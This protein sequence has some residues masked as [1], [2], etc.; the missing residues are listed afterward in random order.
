VKRQTEHERRSLRA[1][2][3]VTGRCAAPKA[4]SLRSPRSLRSR[5]VANVRG[6]I[7]AG[8]FSAVLAACSG[9]PTARVPEARPTDLM[10]AATVLPPM[11]EGEVVETA[12]WPRS[13]RASR[14]VIEADGWLR[15]AQGAETKGGAFPAR[16]RWLSG[17]EMDELWRQL[18][19]S[20]L[21]ARDAPGRVEGPEEAAGSSSKPVALIYAS[22]DGRRQT[23]RVVMDRA[24]PE[25]VEAERVVDRLAAFAWER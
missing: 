21:L 16:T 23:V 22:W 18:A 19:G 7:L 14:F 9:T 4:G 12:A 15:A 3:E 11:R 24:T 25:A 17:R 2:N 5:L 6:P 8:L 13:L 20:G 1:R 10:V